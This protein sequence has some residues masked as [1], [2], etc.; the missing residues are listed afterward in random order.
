MLRIK[1]LQPL[2]QRSAVKTQPGSVVEITFGVEC[3]FHRMC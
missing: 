3:Y 1:M 2:Y